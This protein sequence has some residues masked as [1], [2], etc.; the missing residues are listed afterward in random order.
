MLTHISNNFLGST[1]HASLVNSLSKKGV[2]EQFVYCPLQKAFIINENIKVDESVLVYSPRIFCKLIRYFPLLKVLYSFFSFLFFIRKNNLKPSF[3]IAHNLWSDG[4]VA[5]LYHKFTGTPYTV[6]VR[7]TD[8]N[9]FIPRLVYYRWLIRK[10]AH[11]SKR[12]IYINKAYSARMKS[13][14]PKIYSSIHSE[15]VI[16][17]GIID[18]WLLFRE[19]VDN[20]K[21]DLKVCFVGSFIKRKNLKNS[22][23]A[24]KNLNQGGSGISFVAIGGSEEDFLSCTELSEIPRWVTVVPKTRDR[25]LISRHLRDS[26]VFLMPS[27]SE[28]FG[29]V[30][31]EALS[32]GCCLIHSENEG[33]DGIFSEP[34][35]KSVEPHNVDDIAN[36]VGLLISKFPC[37]V[38]PE[39][40]SRLT[41][42]FAWSHIA[43]QYL[44]IINEGTTR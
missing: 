20:R 16:Y 1:V 27:F 18:E 25:Q 26:R 23:R 22:V 43:E 33:I 8:I 30:Y 28:T 31:I 32:Q 4:M 19:L 36:K 37:G 41:K 2:E 7:D 40:V 42:N 6:A 34:F 10:V 14:Y 13:A 35:I 9:L 38:D 29:L 3:V 44:E 17:N 11:N 12:V 21:R 5:W 15:Q 39:D 24:I